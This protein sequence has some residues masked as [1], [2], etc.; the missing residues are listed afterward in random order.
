MTSVYLSFREPWDDRDPRERA[1]MIRGYVM[2]REELLAGLEELGQFPEV[3]D[4]FK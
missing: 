1:P 2:R 4:E 3:P